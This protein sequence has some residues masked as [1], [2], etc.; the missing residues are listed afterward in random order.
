L[1]FKKGALIRTLEGVT[2]IQ[3]GK[4]KTGDNAW[5][6]KEGEP[7]HQ[8]LPC[9]APSVKGRT[10]PSMHPE[11]RKPFN[12]RKR[13]GVKRPPDRTV[14]RKVIPGGGGLANSGGK[15]KASFSR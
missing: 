5:A 9:S 8:K 13:F 11:R 1:F 10:H 12:R 14:P 2:N 15:A 3:K 6:S 7:S 4:K